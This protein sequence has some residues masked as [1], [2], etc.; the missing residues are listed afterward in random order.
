MLVINIFMLVL[1]QNMRKSHKRRLNHSEVQKDLVS[2]LK[3]KNIYS[4]I[5]ENLEYSVNGIC[6]ETDVIGV[7]FSGTY[8]IYEVKSNCKKYLKAKNQMRRHSETHP[9]M[10]AKYVFFSPGK[11]KRIYL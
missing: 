10:N 3:N 4:S 8:H 11:C 6:G 9:E 2:R 1:L 7:T 5:I